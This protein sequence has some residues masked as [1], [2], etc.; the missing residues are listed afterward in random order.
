M[1]HAFVLSDFVYLVTVGG[2][3]PPWAFPGLALV[4]GLLVA[5]F[6]KRYG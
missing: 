6:A 4:V 2:V 5:F 1:V 3:V